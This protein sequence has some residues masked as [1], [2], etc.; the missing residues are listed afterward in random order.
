MIYAN[1]RA[2]GMFQF[3]LTCKNYQTKQSFTHFQ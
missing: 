3:N 2:A 1:T